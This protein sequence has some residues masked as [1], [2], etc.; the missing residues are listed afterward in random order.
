MTA[1]EPSGNNPVIMFADDAQLR[2]RS[3]DGL[4][5][6]LRQAAIWAAAHNM[7]WNVAKCSIICSDPNEGDPLK[8]AGEVVREVTQA[9]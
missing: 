6:L 2:A 9:E 5:A 8:L 3:K 7:I 4:Q 1:E